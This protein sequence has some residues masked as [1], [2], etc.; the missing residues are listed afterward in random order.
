MDTLEKD[1][2]LERIEDAQNVV[3]HV[4]N[5]DKFN[6]E[7][8]PWLKQQLEQMHA[9]R[10][11]LAEP[12]AYFDHNGHNGE[13]NMVVTSQHPM[14]NRQR[15]GRTRILREVQDRLGDASV[16]TVQVFGSQIR[17]SKHSN[18]DSD[19]PHP[20][21]NV[22]L[23]SKANLYALDDFLSLVKAKAKAY[24]PEKEQVEQADVVKKPIVVLNQ[25][26]GGL[27]D[28]H[29]WDAALDAIGIR[30]V[31]EYLNIT[32]VE[33]RAVAADVIAGKLA[34][35][36][37]QQI[38]LEGNRER[39]EVLKPGDTIFLH[40][41]TLEKLRDYQAIFRE[42]GV[43]VRMLGALGAVAKSPKELSGSFEGNAEE[44]LRAAQ[45]M[46]AQIPDEKLE[47]IFGL[48]RNQ[49]HVMVDDS[50]YYVKDRRVLDVFDTTDMEHLLNKQEWKANDKPFPGVELG[51]FMNAANGLLAFKIRLKEAYDGIDAA[52]VA[53]A[54]RAKANGQHYE[55]IPADRGLHDVACLAISPAPAYDALLKEYKTYEEKLEHVLAGTQGVMPDFMLYSDKEMLFVFPPRPS[56]K[57]D[58][59]ESKHFEVPIYDNNTRHKRTMAELEE[60][61]V[62]WRVKNSVRSIAARGLMS[63]LSL[64][65][66]K[67]KEYIAKKQ[68]L[69]DA[70][71]YKV[72]VDGADALGIGD[73]LLGTKIRDEKSAEIAQ[74][75]IK[76][77]KS[78]A[79][80]REME[81][82]VQRADALVMTPSGSTEG[83][84]AD[85]YE[86]A[87][88]FWSLVVAR[89]THP[90]DVD[91]PLIIHNPNHQFDGLLHQYNALHVLGAIKEKPEI[92][93]QEI[94]SHNVGEVTSYLRKERGARVPVANYTNEGVEDSVTRRND[95]HLFHTAVFCS[96]TSE[97]KTFQ[98]EVYHLAYDEAMKGNGIVYG[99]GSNYMMGKIAAG[100]LQAQAEINT[101][102]E[103]TGETPRTVAL[104]GSNMPHL[105]DREG[106]PPEHML[107]HKQYL[108]ADTIYQRM[109]YMID[110]SNAFVVA[111]G[112]AGTMQEL[113][114]L[115]MLKAKH[116]P[117]MADKEIILVNTK[118][119][120][121]SVV[122]HMPA[123]E[124]KVLHVHVADDMQ[125]ARNTL[126]GI[127]RRWQDEHL[128]ITPANDTAGNGN[129]AANPHYQTSIR[130]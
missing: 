66:S 25:K 120:F 55:A 26:N 60:R 19:N 2:L 75:V 41:T 105:S 30:N 61:D 86:Q 56:V 24:D 39:D 130:H 34:D 124:L 28:V 15:S 22:F 51:P 42:R 14:C 112:G 58:L 127:Q 108:N 52:E 48:K 122:E 117:S 102:A 80:L 1:T 73:T 23:L 29:Y 31:K 46:M 107:E 63:E 106:L 67:A 13:A 7:T 21:A 44:K 119:F 20:Y 53:K 96:A 11:V 10:Y 110:S 43:T 4:I 84:I 78:L 109:E 68:T 76:N 57:D 90:R 33:E 37:V 93:L 3:R 88:K 70:A 98:D 87:F 92:L 49:A 128:P 91:K 27:G 9:D 69:D 116:D 115:L 83:A 126:V 18:L 5:G 16:D 77:N 121:D 97:N 45:V 123:D 104:S 113:S 36:R 125:Q 74:E 89:Q 32:E 129:V 118:G 50:G 62:Q 64:S 85:K 111:P 8:Y 47:N 103:A 65:E 79:T 114:A 81:T 71:S 40:T 101:A 72:L 12:S 35:R 54:K 38:A 17:D 6:P 99:G 100:A 59:Y 82:L 94:T 95:S